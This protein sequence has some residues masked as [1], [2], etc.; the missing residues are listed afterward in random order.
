MCLGKTHTMMGTE[1]EKG[2]IPLCLDYI[3]KAI[4]KLPDERMFLLG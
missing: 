3:F 1:A 4:D 2:I